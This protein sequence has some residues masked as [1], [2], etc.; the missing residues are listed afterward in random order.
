MWKV[1]DK[2]RVRLG[3]NTYIDTPNL[4]V[5]RG[6]SLFRIRRG[7]DGML[8]ID[9]DVFDNQGKRVAT[10]AKGAVVQ[11]DNDKYNIESG[12][13]TYTVTEKTS[14]RV[15]TRVQ[16]RGVEGAE[17]D[18]WVNTYL[19]NGQLLA[20]TPTVTNLGG[21]QMTGCTFERCGAGIAIG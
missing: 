8:G 5:F 7:D 20:A 11:G 12:H 1:E 2:F 17:L 6:E 21:F 15:I 9:F 10:I 16:R 3:G 18:V 13:E 14:G 19:P 4:I